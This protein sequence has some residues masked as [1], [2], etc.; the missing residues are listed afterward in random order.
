MNFLTETPF[1]VGIVMTFLSFFIVISLFKPNK[2]ELLGIKNWKTRDKWQGTIVTTEIKSW[3]QT[4]TKYG[5]D[6]FYNFDF[7]IDLNGKKKLYTA[8][9]L[10]GPNDIHK[11]RKGMGIIVKYNEDSPPKVAVI[12]VIY[13]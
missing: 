6:F 5:N 13:K 9:G 7:P 10:V 11:L 12:D 3:S 4:E 8:K 2:N 1:I